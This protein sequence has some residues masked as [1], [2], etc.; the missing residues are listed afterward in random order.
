MAG[1]RKVAIESSSSLL[2]HWE[3]RS[4]LFNLHVA[5]RLPAGTDACAKW[6]SFLARLE[7]KVSALRLRRDIL[8]HLEQ[9]ESLDTLPIDGNASQLTADPAA[10]ERFAAIVAETERRLLSMRGSGFVTSASHLFGYCNRFG[11]E[12]IVSLI[13]RVQACRPGTPPP[14][15][16]LLMRWGCALG[17]NVAYG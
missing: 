2:A 15:P 13:Q 4:E 8:T 14:V 3:R 17:T 12:G 9:A 11:F 10:A 16:G 1:P 6:T 7:T 5:M